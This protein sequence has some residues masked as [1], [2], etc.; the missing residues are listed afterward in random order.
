MADVPS[1]LRD[2][3]PTFDEGARNQDHGLIDWT[4]ITSVRLARN[5]GEIVLFVAL[6]AG[7]F[8][9]VQGI[10]EWTN[11]PEYVVPHPTSVVKAL[12]DHFSLNYGHPLWVTLQEFLLGVS[13]GAT[14]GLVLAAIIT[15]VP[16]IERL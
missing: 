6:A 16:F 4:A 10:L 15:Q 13:I 2:E 9:L 1:E 11:E 12:G 3:I 8:W 14:V 7:I 5:L